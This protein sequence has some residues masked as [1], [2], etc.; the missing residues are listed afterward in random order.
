LYIAI[1]KAY[2]L[3]LVGMINFPNGPVA[4]GNDFAIV[5]LYSNALSSS[6]LFV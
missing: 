5:R 6:S 4:V 2:G 1:G 3:T